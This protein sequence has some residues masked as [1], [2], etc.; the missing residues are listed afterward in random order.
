MTRN[1]WLGGEVGMEASLWRDC[2]VNPYE[3]VWMLPDML[4]QTDHCSNPRMSKHRIRDDG[5]CVSPVAVKGDKL[6]QNM[7]ALVNTVG[8]C[9]GILFS[10]FLEDLGT[11]SVNVAWIYNARAFT[12][13]LTQLLL[14][15]LVL[16]LG[17]RK[18]A[19][20]AGFLV[21]FGLGASAFADSAV[22][23]LFSYSLMT[24]IG[25][26]LEVGLLFTIIPHYFKRKRG[27]ANALMNLGISTGQ[28]AGPLLISYL[29]G[30]YGFCGS[31]LILSAIVLNC[32]VGASVFHPVEWHKRNKGSGKKCEAER[33][34]IP[35]EEAGALEA[36]AR[37]FCNVFQNLK[38]LRSPKVLIIGLGSSLNNTGFLNFLM[39]APFAL[40]AA[41][42]SLEESS[43]CMSVFGLCNLVTRLLVSSLTDWPKFSKRGC[44][45]VG[46]AIAFVSVI[47]FSFLRD[48]TWSKVVMGLWGC[49]V[50]SFMGI[51]SLI[52]VEY[53]GLEKLVST[54]G[55]CGIMNGLCFILIGPLI[56]VI[57]DVSQSYAVSMWALSGCFAISF[58]LWA[59]MPAAVAYDRRREERQRNL[60]A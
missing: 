35:E 43:W 3:K 9:F 54:L 14:G 39:M 45:M 48:L 42:H 58:C 20:F 10:R 13:C 25:S 59:L 31:T 57:R 34:L 44:Y 37:F 23:L 2:G 19:F 6:I 1:K 36:T 18:V 12:L 60:P 41:R 21:A 5:A 8:P 49:G 11:S 32:C 40:Q 52:M 17:W 7:T 4:G 27:I 29:Q 56:G 47:S 15:P 24:G 38:L 28:M 30:L 53:V 16:E 33:A 26:G 22:Y 50:G 46:T 55:V 51:H